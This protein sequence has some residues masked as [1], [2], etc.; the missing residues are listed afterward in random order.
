MK[1]RVIQNDFFNDEQK[2]AYQGM[3]LCDFPINIDKNSCE[4]GIIEINTL[5]EF[6]KF[7]EL[8]DSEVTFNN[9]PKGFP[10]LVI[11]NEE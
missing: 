6:I 2:R 8:V 9:Y 4:I 7:A 1:F 5:E 10:T 11:Q 3:L